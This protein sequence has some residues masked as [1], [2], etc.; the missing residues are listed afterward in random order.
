[1]LN[2]CWVTGSG[3]GSDRRVSA[4]P[5]VVSGHRDDI[6][7]GLPTAIGIPT[8]VKRTT[9]WE[10][11]MYLE[12][13]ISA[14]E[15]YG[16]LKHFTPQLVAVRPPA[17]LG[18]DDWIYVQE[19]ASQGLLV[20]LHEQL[21]QLGRSC[22]CGGG[23][24]DAK[25]WKLS[26]VDVTAAARRP[27]VIDVKIG[28]VRHSPYTLPGKLEAIC[29]KEL[30]R[31]Q[32]I[33]ITGAHHE[34]YSPTSVSSRLMVVEQFT[35]EMGYALLSDEA[36][37]RA[38]RLFFSS[39]ASMILSDGGEVSDDND[40]SCVRAR[41]YHCCSRVR[42]LVDFFK[43]ELGQKLLENTAFVST[44]LLLVYDAAENT[45]EA[46][47]AARVGVYLIDFARSGDRRLNF[48]EDVIR[49]V[50]GLEEVLRLLLFKDPA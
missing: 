11:L 6:E 47:A 24:M 2:G 28:A 36:N 17:H 31:T 42:Q 39:R 5:I 4:E 7:R 3:G 23:V 34:I 40:N 29:K 20:A 46:A 25:L 13:L 1:M 33:R 50:Q 19:P 37:S 35:K 27:C 41:L 38:L 43:S 12:M 26:M 48:S 18:F 44:S 16:E 15:A 32:L 14:N 21:R 30:G 10:A 49:F 45:C 9:A 8:I 22:E